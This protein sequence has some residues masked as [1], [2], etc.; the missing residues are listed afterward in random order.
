MITKLRRLLYWN[1]WDV[2]CILLVLRQH[3]HL[4]QPVAMNALDWPVRGI[5]MFEHMMASL[6][7]E[8]LVCCYVN[9]ITRDMLYVNTSDDSSVS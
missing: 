1:A 3:G 8:G 9:P 4:P 6:E 7:V 5:R 2:D